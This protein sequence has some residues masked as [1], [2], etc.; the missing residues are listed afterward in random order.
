V[1][2]ALLDEILATQHAVQAVHPQARFLAF[3][4]CDGTILKGDCSEGFEEN[5]RVVYAGLA[6]LCVEHGFA[7]RYRPAGGFAECWRD[8][9]YLDEHVGHWLAYPYFLQMLAGARTDDVAALARGHFERILRPYVFATAQRLLDGL[10]AAGVEN[11]IVTASAEVFVR[12]ASGCLGVPVER[13][14]GIRGREENGRLTTELIYP[15]TFAEG[16]RARLEEIVAAAQRETPGREIIVLA[17]FGNSYGTDGPFLAFT[18]RQQLPAGHAV[19]VMFNGGEEPERYRG[20]FRR[21]EIDA[22]VG[23]R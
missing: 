4:D 7:A 19:A 22:V 3:W 2:N 20:L 11:H 16:K 12:G 17:A 18:A 15:V 1:A 5:G 21:M 13:I 6:Q 8:Y 23:P 9:R 14:H 10:A